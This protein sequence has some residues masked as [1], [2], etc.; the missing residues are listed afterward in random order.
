MHIK[1]VT[2]EGFK[3]YKNRIKLGPLSR[4][5]SCV[6]GANGSGKSN[7]FAAISFVLGELGSGTL[8]E[9]DRKLLLHEGVGAA[10]TSAYVEICFDNSEGHFPDERTEIS[11][12]RLVTLRKDDYCAAS[13]AQTPAH[14]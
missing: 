10:A 14:A 9:Q 2:I 5:H 13:D 7:F 11:I 8:R 3:V 1:T 6:V 12:K 4:Q